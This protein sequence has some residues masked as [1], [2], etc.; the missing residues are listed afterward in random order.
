[1][2]LSKKM[3]AVLQK[4]LD[5]LNVESDIDAL[6][7]YVLLLDKWNKAYNLTAIRAVDEMVSRHLIDSLAMQKLLMGKRVID[8]GTGAGLPGIPLAITQPDKQFVLLDSNGKKMR[9]LREVKRQLHLTNIEL[10]D[11]RVEAYRPDES[12]DVVTSRAFSD[13]KKMIDW[14]A[15]LKKPDGIW[16]AMKGKYPTEELK[17]IQH[18]YKVHTYKVPGVDE[19]RCCVEIQ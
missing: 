6:I 8:V 13:L 1:M 5:D 12:F 3:Y 4:G 11:K 17:A 9:F 7:Q 2:S 10:V 16:L 15:H 18:P 14:T 19:E